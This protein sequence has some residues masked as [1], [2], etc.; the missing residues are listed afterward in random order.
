MVIEDTPHLHFQRSGARRF[1]SPLTAATAVAALLAAACV[2]GDTWPGWRGGEREGRSESEAA[3][4]YW[5][6]EDNVAWRSPIP[7][8]GHSSPILTED[9]LLV[10]TA[11][12]IRRHGVA[13]SF[14][15]G[16]VLFG[17]AVVLGMGIASILLSVQSPGTGRSGRDWNLISLGALLGLAALI[18]LFGRGLFAF[19]QAAESAWL[20]AALVGTLLL[21]ADWVRARLA[22]GPG[23]VQAGSLPALAAVLLITVPEGIGA[24][25]SEPDAPRSVVV[26]GVV[27]L[28]LIVGLLLLGRSFSEERVFARATR[29]L[30]G[31]CIVG[32]SLAVAGAAL[33]QRGRGGHHLNSLNARTGRRRPVGDSARPWRCG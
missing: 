3:P 17:L 25:L 24:A 22:A 11:T 26:W 18:L 10:T 27:A 33:L 13:A 5:S 7:G 29:W 9:A 16:V 4:V 12:E 21:A 15:G 14:V 6:A 23:S 1:V 20:A 2:Q 8:A 30:A 31:M 28:P 19:G 32:L